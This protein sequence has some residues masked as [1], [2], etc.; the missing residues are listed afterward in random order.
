L[1][2]AHGHVLGRGEAGPSN[3][4]AVGLEKAMAAIQAAVQQAWEAAALPPQRAAAA[5]LG[6]AGVDRAED[7]SLVERAVRS[8]GLAR[9][10]HIVNDAVIALA[11][12]TRTGIGVVV[13]AGT[14]S[15]AYGM[16]AQ[17]NQRRAGGWGHLIGDEGSAYDIGRRALQ[18]VMRAYDGR[19]PQ[20]ALTPAILQYWQISSPE[21]II[22]KIYGPLLP[23]PQ[24]A[25]LAQVVVATARQGDPVARSILNDA[26]HE[27]VTTAITVIRHLG[28]DR[29][30][31]EVA[32]A[33]GM[34]R[35][36]DLIYAPFVAAL[37][38]LVPGAQVVVSSHE[39]ALGAVKLAQRL[40]ENQ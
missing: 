28:M 38:A 10:V 32:V 17:G 2:D 18:A 30:P 15:I 27:L 35:T 7:H 39:P 25:A 23:R 19:G 31:V 3:Y 33:G 11:A 6:L 9:Q 21:D 37:R 5:C 12:A 1:A 4:Q 36:E 20:T 22:S 29:S 14:G 26:V 34:F 8:L 24:I 13:I 40:V 16:N